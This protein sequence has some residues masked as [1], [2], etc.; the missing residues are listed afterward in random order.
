MTKT[1]FVHIG[2]HK[3]ATTTIQRALWENR[4]LLNDCGILY[5]KTNHYHYAQHRI[6]FAIRGMRDPN[7]GDVPDICFELTE[8]NDTISKSSASKV[9]ISSESFFVAPARGI[10]MLK[11]ATSRFDV[12]ILAFVR[13]QDNY[14]LSIYNQK[15]KGVGNGFSKPLSH[16]VANPRSLDREI[17]FYDNIMNWK[18]VFGSKAIRLFRYEDH[19]PLDVVLQTLDFH[20]SRFRRPKP[21]NASVSW[22]AAELIRWAKTLG[23]SKRKQSLI[24]K[25]AVN[26]FRP[27]GQSPLSMTRRKKIVAAFEDENEALF[28]YFGMKNTY[29]VDFLS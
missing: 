13:R 28:N 11:E 22:R 17:S 4:A 27:S 1:L 9:L 15:I 18:G 20:S 14:L 6:G 19:D 2:A 24:Q 10:E 26:A 25:F 29:R 3:T 16:F 12:V 8:L 21:S 5:P 23:L 7:R